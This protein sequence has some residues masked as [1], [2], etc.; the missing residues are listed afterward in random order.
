M[1]INLRM[2]THLRTH[3][4]KGNVTIRRG[5]KISIK[6][7]EDKMQQ[8]FINNLDVSKVDSLS[9]QE[10][11]GC[12]HHDGEGFHIKAFVT[13]RYSFFW[14]VSLRMCELYQVSIG[15][16]LW[17]IAKLRR[18]RKTESEVRTK[19]VGKAFAIWH[20]NRQLS[21]RKFRPPCP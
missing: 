1:K 20:S 13:T 3:L 14:G 19:F 10:F 8:Y 18:R 4:S 7:N 2:W 11:L 6:A 21:R 9:W 16:F 17:V 5:K 12:S 15:Y